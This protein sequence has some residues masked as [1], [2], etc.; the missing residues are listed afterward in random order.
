MYAVV[1]Y[2]KAV[3]DTKKSKSYLANKLLSER[4]F[5]LVLRLLKTL[6][7]HVDVTDQLALLGG[8]G[9]LKKLFDYFLFI[10]ES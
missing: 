4:Q 6:P 7:G 9:H 10:N 5:S 8:V 2:R 1:Y 3:R